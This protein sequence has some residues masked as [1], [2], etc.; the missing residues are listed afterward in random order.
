MGQAEHRDRVVQVDVCQYTQHMKV[1]SIKSCLNPSVSHKA[2]ATKFDIRTVAVCQS[3]VG[4][5]TVAVCQSN[6]GFRTVTVCQSKFSSRTVDVCQSILRYLI[7]ILGRW[8]LKRDQAQHWDSGS[9]PVQVVL[10]T[11]CLFISGFPPPSYF[12][13]VFTL[14]LS[15]H[16]PNLI[17]IS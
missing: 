16:T 3:K 10:G 1:I 8:L 11:F 14:M 5:K 12:K 9:M 7:V 17:H 6:V 4:C 13:G 15:E 2:V